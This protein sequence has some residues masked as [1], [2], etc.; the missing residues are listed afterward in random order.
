MQV[1]VLTLHPMPTMPAVATN[2]IPHPTATIVLV[3]IGAPVL[4]TVC[5]H[6]LACTPSQDT[7]IDTATRPINGVNLYIPPSLHSRNGRFV[8]A[9][10]CFDYLSFA[11]LCF[12][13][14]LLCV[15][16]PV[17]S[18]ILELHTFFV[19]LLHKNYG[20]GSERSELGYPF[21]RLE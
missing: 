19:K 6:C 1:D 14:L 15:I 7:S 4:G 17:S 16:L 11:S 18:I 8:T 5:A 2:P 9:F 3:I 21:S 12:T 10:E 13:V 20:L